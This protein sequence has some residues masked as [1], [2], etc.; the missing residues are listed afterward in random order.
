MK[1]TI[2]IPDVVNCDLCGERLQDVV[3]FDAVIFDK[4]KVRVKAW[5]VCSK[6]GSDV[7]FRGVF[8]GTE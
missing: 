8:E 4:N 3:E 6:C 5:L 2:D 7:I 1:F